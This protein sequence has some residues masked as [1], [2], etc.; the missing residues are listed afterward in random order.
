MPTTKTTKTT[1]TSKTSKQAPKTQTPFDKLKQ[2]MVTVLEAAAIV[3]DCQQKQCPKETRDVK[4]VRMDAIKQIKKD[5]KD[6]ANILQN[7]KTSDQVRS[8]NNCSMKRCKKEETKAY[9]KVFK[10]VDDLNVCN[11]PKPV[12]KPVTEKDKKMCAIIHKCK[13]AK[14]RNLCFRESGLGGL[15]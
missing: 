4:K 1:K 15:L 2:H 11:G 3:S 12:R 8:L 7:V 14:N 10:M 13:A 5:P 6:M 9:N